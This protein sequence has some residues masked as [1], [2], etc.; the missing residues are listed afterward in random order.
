V[1]RLRVPPLRERR[2]D[3]PMLF[4]HF[5]NVAA[6][7]LGVPAPALSHGVRRRLMDDD[8]PGNVR[9]LSHYAERV[10]TGIDEDDSPIPE[11]HHQGLS[12]SVDD[13][14]KLALSSALQTCRG[15]INDVSNRLK[16]PRKTLYDKLR[17]HRLKP[18]DYR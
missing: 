17:K 4:A 6:Q 16:L 8:W 13:F 11:L 10:V 9:E 7:Q 2:E 3:I 1:I 5:L 15:Q 18:S 14:E 12:E